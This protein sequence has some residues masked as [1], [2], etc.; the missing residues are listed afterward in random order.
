MF[1]FDQ[2]SFDPSLTME[3]AKS[4]DKHTPGELWRLPFKLA[5]F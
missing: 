5:R 1:T 2:F 4:K 3:M